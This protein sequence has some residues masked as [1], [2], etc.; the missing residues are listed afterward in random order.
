MYKVSGQIDQRKFAE[1]L[2]SIETKVNGYGEDFLDPSWKPQFT[3]EIAVK[4]IVRLY[5][6]EYWISSFNGENE[7]TET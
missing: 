3:P 2:L 7:K 1:R 5:S 4:E 6:E